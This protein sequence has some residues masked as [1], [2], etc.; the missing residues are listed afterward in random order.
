MNES[1]ICDK[2][3]EIYN[4]VLEDET[5]RK[6]NMQLVDSTYK[7][8]DNTYITEIAFGNNGTSNWPG[9]LTHLASVLIE[10]EKD[11]NINKICLTKLEVDIF[12]DIS[13]AY[14][15]TVLNE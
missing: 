6:Y 3:D 12:D 15:S 13:I 8:E 9:Y 4:S 14:I 7:D 2:I 11:E 10:V 5:F 1:N